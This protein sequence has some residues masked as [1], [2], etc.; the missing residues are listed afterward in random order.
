MKIAIFGSGN[1]GQTLGMG[2]A[3]FGHSVKMGS[4]T[5][6]SEK[7]TNWIRRAGA[8]AS[9]GTY[10]EAASFGQVAVLA[11]AWS[12]TENAIGLA[13]ADNLVGKVVI[14]V[15]NPLKGASDDLPSLALG[16]TDSAGEQVQRWLPRSDVVKAFNIVGFAHM[17]HPMFAGG[18]PDM[19]ICGNDSDAKETV[20]GFLKD[21][22]WQ[23]VDVGGIQGAR[24]LE[25]LALLWILHGI[26]TGTWNHAF[27]LL[28]K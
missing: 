4:R 2:F 10:A 8:L 7:V 5:P 28:K 25:P 20:T 6:K 11:T 1:V 22:G 21:F 13:G 16:Q 27:K 18:P 17:V 15:T 9:A 26:R 19:F 24:L 12:G 3:G 14:D 23:V